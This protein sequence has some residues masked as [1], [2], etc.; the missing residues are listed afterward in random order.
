MLWMWRETRKRQEEQRQGL[1]EEQKLQER[2]KR[3]KEEGGLGET[4]YLSFKNCL[5]YF[6]AFNS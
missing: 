3:V 5:S 2:R 4:A 1:R 6:G